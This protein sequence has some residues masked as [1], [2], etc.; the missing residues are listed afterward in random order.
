MRRASFVCVAKP[1][2]SRS[3]SR[4][5]S[6]S[7]VS[8]TASTTSSSSSHLGWRR[9]GSQHFDPLR[10]SGRSSGELKELALEGGGFVVGV[11]DARPDGDPAWSDG[12][13][14]PEDVETAPAEAKMFDE[15]EDFRGFFRTPVFRFLP[16]D[17]IDIHVGVNKVAISRSTDCALEISEEILSTD[18]IKI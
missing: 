2:L 17:Q 15:M 13:V 12:R 7:I 8:P 9:F 11:G 1:R 5:A 16:D 4:P 6:P 10:A 14:A 18:A 3:A